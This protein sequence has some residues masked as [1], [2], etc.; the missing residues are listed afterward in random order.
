M[1]VGAQP[2]SGR[3]RART[4]DPLRGTGR[5]SR[6]MQEAPRGAMFVWCNFGLDYPMW[7]ARKLGREDLMIVSPD[8]LLQD[9]LRGKSGPVIVIDH[10]AKLT[11]AQSRAYLRLVP[12]IQPQKEP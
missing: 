8:A 4:P 6:Q 1:S 12:A 7:L 11:K 2:S 10:D 3:L 5:T 9:W